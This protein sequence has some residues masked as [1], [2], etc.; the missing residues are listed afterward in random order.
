M[1]RMQD[2]HDELFRRH[3]IQECLYA[4]IAIITKWMMHKM[5]YSQN[6]L[7]K[8]RQIKLHKLLTLKISYNGS[9]KN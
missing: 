6:R 1:C 7:C 8:I 4:R 5:N 9:K 3:I 2:V